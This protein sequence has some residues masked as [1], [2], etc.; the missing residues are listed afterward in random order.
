[1]SETDQGISV[2]HAPFIA[3]KD[4]EIE[5]L[6]TAIQQCLLASQVRMRQPSNL[7]NLLSPL[8]SQAGLKSYTAFARMAKL[9]EVS[10]SD[11]SNISFMPTR[12]GGSRE[13]YC[14]LTE[15]MLTST[16][17]VHEM[18]NAALRALAISTLP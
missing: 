15:K 8:L 16:N 4:S 13:G 6:G 5:S 18:G 17:A 10:T 11:N 9:I 14:D 3:V 12:N 7:R 2:A 1:M